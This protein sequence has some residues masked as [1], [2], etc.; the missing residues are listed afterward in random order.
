MPLQRLQAH[1]LM[2][3]IASCA[4]RVRSGS[5]LRIIATRSDE[6][7]CCSC[8]A[9]IYSLRQRALG[10]AE[11]KAQRLRKIGLSIIILYAMR[12]LV[13][14]PGCESLSKCRT[15]MAATQMHPLSERN[16]LHKSSRYMHK[17]KSCNRNMENDLRAT[18]V[19]GTCA[20]LLPSI[21][22][23]ALLQNS[24]CNRQ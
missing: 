20:K 10:R 8:C 1:Q 9:T 5:L 4:I 11:R 18:L 17:P 21:T 15:E 3:N 19:R 6:Y 7:A 24:T 22:Q 2:M 12:I 23:H 14:H 16:A 13:R